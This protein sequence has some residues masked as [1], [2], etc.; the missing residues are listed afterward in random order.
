MPAGREG[1]Q[2][3]IISDRGPDI[4]VT[5][6]LSDRGEGSGTVLL[7]HPSGKV[8]ELMRGHVDPNPICEYSPDLLRQSIYSRLAA[9]EDSSDAERLSQD[10]T[11]RLI[12]SEKIWERRA[13]LPTLRNC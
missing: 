2:F 7:H 3:G 1:V 11:F 5:E 4:L 13:A 10:L 6:E 12:G 8:P 9:Y